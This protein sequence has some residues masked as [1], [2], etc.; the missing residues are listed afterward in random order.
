MVTLIE[1]GKALQIIENGGIALLIQSLLHREVSAV[2][3]PLVKLAN[4]GHL[5]DVIPPLIRKLR[6]SREEEKLF[7]YR[8]LHVCKYIA[9]DHALELSEHGLQDVLLSKFG[10]FTPSLRIETIRIL[11]LLAYDDPAIVIDHNLIE[12]FS[13]RLRDPNFDDEE[14]GVILLSLSI[15]AEVG[16]TEELRNIGLIPEIMRMLKDTHRDGRFYA[17]HALGECSKGFEISEIIQSG[18]IDLLV[19]WISEDDYHAMEAMSS[20][21]VIASNGGLDHIMG[22]HGMEAILDHYSHSSSFTK[23]YRTDE[24]FAS[25]KAFGNRIFQDLTDQIEKYREDPDTLI[26]LVMVLGVL[27]D[28]SIKPLQQI[29][30]HEKKR[31]Y[32]YGSRKKLISRIEE[33]LKTLEAQ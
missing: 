30:H 31:F 4:A 25:L 15:L 1:N 16:H 29:L 24:F 8:I 5:R 17:I 11:G 2:D 6:E 28:E 21:G 14:K 19:R 23:Q 18:G 32:I 3:E 27:G 12:R 22:I 26:L 13:M 7:I 20:L 33:T 9:Y 10:E